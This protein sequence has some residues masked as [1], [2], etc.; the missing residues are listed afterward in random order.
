MT[1]WPNSSLK[2]SLGCSSRGNEA[3]TSK[4]EKESEP[5]HVGCYFMN[6]LLPST[7]L[8]FNSFGGKPHTP[9]NTHMKTKLMIALASVFTFVLV[10]QQ[11]RN[12]PARPGAVEP[13][14]RIVSKLTE[15]VS[16]R[17]RLAK[18]YDEM[19]RAGRANADGLAEVELAEARIELARER[20]QTDAVIAELQG[21]VAVHE[22]R[23]K[24]MSGLTKD[25]VA[26]GEIDRAQAALLEA[27]VRL[28]RAQK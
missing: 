13:D 14:A 6:G 23:I 19:L 1:T 17:E 28:L 2:K 25:R 18:N 3:P 10:A 21:L 4:T 8:N 9:L 12:S 5:P 22:R 16:I 24:R 11:Q 15:I 20:N 26:P 7:W 27:Q